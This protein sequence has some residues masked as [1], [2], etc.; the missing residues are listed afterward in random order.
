MKNVSCS[1]PWSF[2]DWLSKLEPTQR[3]S[4]VALNRF[5]EIRLNLAAQIYR[6][7]EFNRKQALRSFEKVVIRDCSNSTG[8]RPRAISLYPSV[9]VP[10]IFSINGTI[11][12][13]GQRDIQTL[14]T[15][16]CLTPTP[17]PKNLLWTTK[18]SIQLSTSFL[19]FPF[20]KRCVTFP[21]S[22]RLGRW[23]FLY[24]ET[25][26]DSVAQHFERQLLRWLC[27]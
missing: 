22:H 15:P 20:C 10:R 17:L 3:I 21:P 9:Y 12:L 24:I 25:L 7:K 19:L 13:P 14:F 27:F 18:I 5:V 6:R 11:Q 8:N 23:N 26:T 1:A 16:F 4:V 2:Y